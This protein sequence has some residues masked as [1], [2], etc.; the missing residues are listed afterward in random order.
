MKRKLTYIL[1]ITT[2]CIE[3]FSL[4][5]YNDTPL[6]NP[7]VQENKLP[8]GEYILVRSYKKTTQLLKSDNAK[9]YLFTDRDNMKDSEIFV[10]A[11]SRF[12]DIILEASALSQ[13]EFNTTVEKAIRYGDSSAS[14]TIPFHGCERFMEEIDKGI[15][16][17]KDDG[18]YFI[19]IKTGDKS[20]DLMT[21]NTFWKKLSLRNLLSGEKF[22][23]GFYN[24]YI[25]ES[26]DKNIKKIILE[27]SGKIKKSL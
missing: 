24:V 14:S 11:Y 23:A 17:K 16:P 4:D 15:K 2:L 19:Y 25:D 5:F 13:H 3:A 27:Y 1:L 10:S 21:I 8:W 12:G 20:T 9:I 22:P 26:Y 18:N 7:R 6:L